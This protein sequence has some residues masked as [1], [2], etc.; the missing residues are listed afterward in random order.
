MPGLLDLA[1]CR[2]TDSAFVTDVQ[3]LPHAETDSDHAPYH[4]AHS[5]ARP[6]P[7]C[8]PGPTAPHPS[9]ALV[10]PRPLA[11]HKLRDPAFGQLS[12]SL[13][14]DPDGE[15]DSFAQHMRTAGVQT[16]G[17][18]ESAVSTWRSGHGDELRQLALASQTAHEATV[19]SPHDAHAAQHLRN[20]RHHNRAVVRRLKTAWWHEQAGNLLRAADAHDAVSFRGCLPFG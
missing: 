20:I 10:R 16:L 8:A 6:V 1:L 19:R 2:Q 15:F 14:A 4:V 12:R 17:L 11:V 7:G 3:A 13:Q 9:P 18:A 5:R